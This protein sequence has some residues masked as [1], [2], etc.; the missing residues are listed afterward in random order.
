MGLVHLFLSFLSARSAD[1]R[2]LPAGTRDVTALWEVM[3]VLAR[4]GYALGEQLLN[5]P[6]PKGQEKVL[7]ELDCRCVRRGHAV[8]S[9]T[10]P[11]REKG[12]ED[13]NDEE[14]AVP[15]KKNVPRGYT[16]LERLLDA[17]WGLY[18]QTI[19]RKNFC[20]QP[21]LRAS[22]RAGYENRFL[23]GFMQ[24]PRADYA[25]LSAC[26]GSG[27]KK[28]RGVGRTAAFL[29]NQPEIWSNGPR[30]IGF[31]GM[32]SLSTLAWAYLLRH[33]HSELL[34][35]PGFHMVE[36]ETREVPVRVPDHSW[37][38]DWN[39]ELILSV[40]PA[41]LSPEIEALRPKNS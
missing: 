26:N 32:D 7:L 10:R 20:L 9:G 36:L 8:L 3:A 37:A 25:S 24:G 40:P 5:Y 6:A 30:Y 15:S 27:E 21:S 34:L 38:L 18:F 33:R 11:T 16:D 12:A 23:V 29:L 4:A 41:R 19:T 28:V 17:V 31:F 35:E 22:L 2:I 14:D 13:E 39:A 1:R